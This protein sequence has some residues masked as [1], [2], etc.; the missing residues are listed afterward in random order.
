M[1]RKTMRKWLAGKLFD[2]VVRL[3]WNVAL[4]NSLAVLLAAS[5][6]RVM[7]AQKKKVGRPLGSKDKKPRKRPVRKVQP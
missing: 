5:E 6:V 1:R 2:L 4:V 3:D 7:H